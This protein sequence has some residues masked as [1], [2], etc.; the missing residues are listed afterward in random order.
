MIMCHGID[1]TADELRNALADSR[2][3]LTMSASG[4]P[5]VAAASMSRP[6][7]WSSALDLRNLLIDYCLSL[8][9]VLLWLD[10]S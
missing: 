2:V 6:S 5:T 9:R 1:I 7:S 4:F 3:R 10:L 8:P